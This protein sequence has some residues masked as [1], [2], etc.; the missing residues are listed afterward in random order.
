M[1]DFRYHATSLAAVFV[2][3]LVG[4]LLGVAIGDQGL[5]SSAERDLR[6]NLRSDVRDANDRTRTLREQVR[7]RDRFADEV[8]PLL[9][10]GQLE[11]R[12]V[13]VLFLGRASSGV[14]DDVRKALDGTG[15][16]RTWVAVVDEPV[17]TTALAVNAQGTRYDGLNTNPDLVKLFGVRMGAQ[18]AQGGRLVRRTR[19]TLLRSLAGPLG[20]VDA[21]VVFRNGPTLK[22]DAD[23]DRGALEE[24]IAEGL[25]SSGA[26]TVGVEQISTDPSQIT[27]YRDHG[28][29]SVDDIDQVAGRAA[30]VFALSASDGSFGIKSTADALLP[31]VVGGVPQP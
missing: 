19:K 31:D 6:A 7:E 13:G 1:F 22:G 29:T 11:A 30:L 14:A 10:G 8:Y 2:A 9:V 16:K 25:E 28:L 20:P 17:N 4:L 27:W 23:R 3:L 24:G 18:L 21:V 5:V 12:R 15:A 26:R